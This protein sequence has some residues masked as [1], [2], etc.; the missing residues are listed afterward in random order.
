[1]L[2][3][4]SRPG[5]IRETDGGIRYYPSDDERSYNSSESG[6]DGGYEDRV[7]SSSL[8]D[9]S[10]ARSIRSFSAMMGKDAVHEDKKERISLSERLANMPALSR[11]TV[12]IQQ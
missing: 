11:L 2:I 7:E 4:R 3:L 10:D 8:R 6:D 9:G 5:S 1:M 12:C